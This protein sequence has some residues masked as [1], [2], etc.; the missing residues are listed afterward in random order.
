MMLSKVDLPQPD[1][2]TMATN[3]PSPTLTVISSMTTRGAA[4]PGD[5]N[6]FVRRST[7]MMAAAA[8]GGRGLLMRSWSGGKLRSPGKAARRP[9]AEDQEVDQHHD[10]HEAHAPGKHHV[11]ARVLEPIHELLPDAAADAEGLGD[12]RDLP[13]QRQSDAQG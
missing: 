9:E 6:R 7:A 12:E 1:G 4:P 13:R 5:G 10:H 11:D 2:P 8:A 3:S